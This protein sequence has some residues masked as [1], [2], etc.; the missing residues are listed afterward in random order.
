MSGNKTCSSEPHSSV[1]PICWEK[2]KLCYQGSHSM[3]E[4]HFPNQSV[5]HALLLNHLY[6]TF[7]WC[8]HEL[9]FSVFVMRE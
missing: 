7:L 4:S 6:F 9:A 8:N 2:G 1:I 3:E 5:K